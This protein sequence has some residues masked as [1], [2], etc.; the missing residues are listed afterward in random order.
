MNQLFEQARKLYP[1]TKRGHD[2][3]YQNFRKKY[4]MRMEKI[5]PLLTPSVEAQI[6][7]RATLTQR[8]DFVP[9]WKHFATWINGAWWTEEI[10]Q[11]GKPKV[12]LCQ[13]CDNHATVR[14]DGKGHRCS[15]AECKAKFELL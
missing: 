3:E 10:P 1:G 13:F 5:L 7:H 11:N 12:I 9:P 14:M 6:A 8:G 15:S 2:V 4:R